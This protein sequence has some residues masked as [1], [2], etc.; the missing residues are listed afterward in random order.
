MGC[1]V[2]LLLVVVAA[3]AAV[4]GVAALRS[5]ELLCGFSTELD[6]LLPVVVDV[7]AAVCWR[8]G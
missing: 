1:L 2:W 6:W 7:G 5:L 3:A 4:S 8:Y